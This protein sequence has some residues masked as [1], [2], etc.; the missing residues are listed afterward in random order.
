MLFFVRGQRVRYKQA[1]L[2][3]KHIHD[4][5]GGNDHTVSHSMISSNAQHDT[6]I[7][8]GC[9]YVKWKKTLHNA[10]VIRNEMLKAH[11]DA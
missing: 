10:I 9:N 1:P 8:T 11:D 6:L 7:V 5:N 3:L 2:S 4:S